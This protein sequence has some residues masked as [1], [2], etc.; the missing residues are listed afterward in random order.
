MKTPPMVR[1]PLVR[2]APL[3]VETFRNCLAPPPP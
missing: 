2:I 3:T 1:I